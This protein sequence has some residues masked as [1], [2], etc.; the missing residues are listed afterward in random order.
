MH[1]K[2]KRRQTLHNELQ[3]LEHRFVEITTSQFRMKSVLNA[4][5]HA[6][7]TVV[8]G[9]VTL[10]FQRDLER[11]CCDTYKGGNEITAQAYNRT[12]LYILYL[13]NV[14]RNCISLFLDN[15]N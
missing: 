15:L 2:F 9:P 14:C 7:V 11:Y 5:K 6:V 1:Y 13:S 3:A 8:K 10:R 12:I 4:D